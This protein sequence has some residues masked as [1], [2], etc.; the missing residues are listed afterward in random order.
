MMRVLTMTISPVEQAYDGGDTL[1]VRRLQEFHSATSS[2]MVEIER[3]I[4]DVQMKVDQCYEFIS[5]VQKFSPDTLTAYK[6]HNTVQRVFD[7]AEQ[8]EFVYAQAETSA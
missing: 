1:N 5:W 8:G 4:R 7:K 3:G 6:A 2:N